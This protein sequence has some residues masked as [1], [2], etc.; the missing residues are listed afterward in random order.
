MK[1]TKLLFLLFIF[2]GSLSAQTVFYVKRSSDNTAWNGRQNVHTDIQAAIDAAAAQVGE[3]NA[4]VWIAKG[5]YLL[6]NSLVPKNGVDVIGGFIGTETAANQYAPVGKGVN[7]TILK[8]GAD[9]V[10]NQ[11]TALTKPA[12]WSNLVITGGQPTDGS[13]EGA[14][15]LLNSG[16]TLKNSII[17]GNK[18]GSGSGA[19]LKGDAQLINCLVSHNE[20]DSSDGGIGVFC[21]ENSKA[22]NCTVTANVYYSSYG[23][24]NTLTAGILVKDNALVANSIS[25]SNISVPNHDLVSQI[26]KGGSGVTITNCA[27]GHDSD[28]SIEGMIILSTV[29]DAWNGPMFV[30]PSD[31]KPGFPEFTPEDNY[32]LQEFSICIDA[33]DNDLVTEEF[34]LNGNKR[35]KKGSYDAETATVDLGAFEFFD[36]IGI[37][38]APVVNPGFYPNPSNGTLYTR[39]E[40]DCTVKVLSISGVLVYETSTSSASPINLSFLPKGCYLLQWQTDNGQG[41]MPLILE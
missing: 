30:N 26:Y 34:D 4:Q 1:K 3:T 33:G 11:T 13:K 21:S 31:P 16:M 32:S 37:E 27:S 19:Y 7:Q 15:A 14:G 9:R 6:S 2:A 40:A 22:V 38:K 10:I 35:I 25:W 12:Y 29:N 5:E 17:S 24:P 8:S 20:G 41:S 39:I 28:S 18:G 36:V 23:G